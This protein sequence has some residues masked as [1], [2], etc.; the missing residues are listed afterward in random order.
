MIMKK[1]Q[2]YLAL[3]A[4]QKDIPELKCPPIVSGPPEFTLST[5]TPGL[6]LI[7]LGG[8]VQVKIKCTDLEQ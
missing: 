5:S 8:A 7:M 6:S 1:R 3:A 2:P 4:K